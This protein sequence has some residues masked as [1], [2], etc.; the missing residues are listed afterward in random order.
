MG[1]GVSDLYDYLDTVQRLIVEAHERLLLCVYTFDDGMTTHRIA[2]A[3]ARGVLVRVL[4]DAVQARAC[5][6]ERGAKHEDAI[7]ILLQ[8]GVEVYTYKHS[9][10]E[11]TPK[12]ENT[13]SPQLHAK[14]IVS[15]HRALVGSKNLTRNGADYRDAGMLT[16]DSHA[17]KRA[18]KLWK[19]YA[20]ES[21]CDELVSRGLA[22]Y[23]DP[24][25][26]VHYVRNIAP[27]RP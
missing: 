22:R 9:A 6:G 2:E 16:S 14:L 21:S 26:N 18:L 20:C 27:P 10:E 5:G 1:H 24:R 12:A 8:A 15:D 19:E 3:A 7:R 13:F 23:F 4:Y 25:I 17:V 11:D